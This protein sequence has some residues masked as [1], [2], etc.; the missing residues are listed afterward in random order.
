MIEGIS[1]DAAYSFD[2][3]NTL[4][5]CR[6]LVPGLGHQIEVESLSGTL[7]ATVS[8]NGL[9]YG[10]TCSHVLQYRLGDHS[11]RDVCAPGKNHLRMLR[12]EITNS[13]IE[14]LH[15]E[16]EKQSFHQLRPRRSN[17]DHNDLYEKLMTL[18]DDIVGHR[19]DPIHLTSNA[20][21]LKNFL[22]ENFINSNMTWVGFCSDF[23][24]RFRM[25]LDTEP[26]LLGRFDPTIGLWHHDNIDDIFVD[27]ALFRL[28][29]D[30]HSRM[31]KVT[32]WDPN[33]DEHG[34]R[35]H[36]HG[37]R[38]GETNGVFASSIISIK[39]YSRASCYPDSFLDLLRQCENSWSFVAKK[40]TLQ[41][42]KK[43]VL[44]PLRTCRGQLVFFN[45]LRAE[46]QF[47]LNG[48][49][50]AVIYRTSDHA[51]VGHLHGT[52]VSHCPVTIATPI[53]HVLRHFRC[54][55]FRA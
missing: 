48:D 16:I 8:R 47:S 38:T 27:A 5:M 12:E 21:T 22:S 32:V 52:V 51:A 50:G 25:V 23:L 34:F 4:R 42:D 6:E 2:C 18:V 9:E 46:R 20:E 36:K 15:K 13:F 43:V 14:R 7:G 55:L 31:K 28:E 45:E 35:V 30:I 3:S 11:V 44:Y 24:D 10:L 29:H 53:S 49:S 54:S 19:S 37:M 26:K 39:K 33:E 17:D 40:D 1:V 41:D